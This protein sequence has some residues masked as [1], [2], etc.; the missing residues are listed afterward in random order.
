MLVAGLTGCVSTT[1]Q[2]D[3]KDPGFRGTF[4]KVIVICV[5][6]EM[7]V[8]N[9]LEDD[10][11]AQFTARGVAAM[12]SYTLFPSLEGVNRDMIKAKVRESGADGVFLVRPV[13]KDTILTRDPGDHWSAANNWYANWDTVTQGAPPVLSVDIYR[14]ESSLYE[15]TGDKIVWQAISDTS[16]S[17]PWMNTLKE[18]ARVMGAKLVER[19]L[20]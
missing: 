1:L 3:W 14:V 4:R 15:T 6:K 19:G 10:I 5:A 16:E 13:G 2:T 18:F 8:R 17:G 20:I 9:T 7:I 11:T 12:P